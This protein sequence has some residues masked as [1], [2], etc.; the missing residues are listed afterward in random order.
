MSDEPNRIFDGLAKLVVNA[1]GIAQGVQREAETAFRLQVEKIA[2][3]LDLV[4]REELEVVKEMVLKARAENADLKKRVDTLEEQS[5][6]K[7][8][9][10]SV[11]ESAQ[12]I[13]T[14]KK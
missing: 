10:V 14:S 1:A 8:K 4:S 3:N 7:I 2:N 6:K 5:R 12:E 13:V 11:Q 9:T